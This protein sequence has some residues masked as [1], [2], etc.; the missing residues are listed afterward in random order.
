MRIRYEGDITLL[1]LGAGASKAFGLPDMKDLTK[2]VIN[3]LK[4]ENKSSYIIDYITRRVEE[5]GLK[6]DIEAVLSC[7]DALRNPVEG[8]KKAGAYAGL[9]SERRNPNERIIGSKEEFEELSTLIR[10]V[11]RKYCGFPPEEKINCLLETYN[12]LLGGFQIS[13]NNYLDVYTT[14][15]DL[16]FETYCTEKGYELNNLS[17]KG[18]LDLNR[19]NQKGFWNII[20]LHGS[21][22]WMLNNKNEIRILDRIPNSGERSLSGSMKEEVMIY[23]TTEKYLSRDPYFSMITAL[24]NDLIKKESDNQSN[25]IVIIG[26]SFRDIAIN[27]SFIDAKKNINFKNKKIYLIDTHPDDILENNVPQM[28]KIIEPVK[29]NFEN[30]INIDFKFNQPNFFFG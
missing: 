4:K 22:N 8:I 20:K 10:D 30:L 16:C 27:N 29:G 6:P 2:F 28:N 19:L 14:N 7:I 17:S 1:F 9:I 26:Y 13:Q 18:K 23:P 12:H 11:I 21:S 5:M 24:R 15:Y 25:Y 3:E